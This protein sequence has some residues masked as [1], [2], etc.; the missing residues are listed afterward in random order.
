MSASIEELTKASDLLS[1]KTFKFTM[2]IVWGFII[3]AAYIT[4]NTEDDSK[5]P[6]APAGQHAPGAHGDHH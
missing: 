1:L 3:V 6:Q 4:I 5:E 2:W